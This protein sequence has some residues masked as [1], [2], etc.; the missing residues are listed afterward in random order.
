MLHPPVRRRSRNS[1]GHPTHVQSTERPRRTMRRQ[2][3]VLACTRPGAYSLAASR[4]WRVLVAGVGTMAKQ[5]IALGL[6]Q[7]GLACTSMQPIQPQT[8]IPVHQPDL[9]SVWT[10]RDD[11]TI[12]SNPQIAGDTRKGHSVRRT[13]GRAAQGRG[14]GRSACVKRP[15]D[16]A[17]GRRFRGFSSGH[18]PAVEH[19]KRKQRHPALWS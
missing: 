7:L 9:V 1:P 13:L 5:G 10:A 8:F 6:L 12:V 3:G 2:D 17:A 18:V 16:S 4:R 19:R 14:A 15:K 11:V